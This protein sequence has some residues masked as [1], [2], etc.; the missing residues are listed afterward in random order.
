MAK[1]IKFAKINKLLKIKLLSLRKL[2]FGIALSLVFFTQTLAFD[3][4]NYEDYVTDLAEVFAAEEELNLENFITEIEQT[5]TVEIAILTIPTT[6]EYDIFDYT[7]EVATQWG[8]GKK[9]NDI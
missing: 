8:V 5:S 4:P 2:F 9:E 3:V 7:Y 1:K 6:G